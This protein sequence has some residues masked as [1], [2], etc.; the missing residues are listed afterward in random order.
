MM[1]KFMMSI[2][3]LVTVLALVGCGEETTTEST[4]GTDVSSSDAGSEVAETSESTEASQSEDNFPQ[5]DITFFVPYGAGGGYDTLARTAAPILEDNLPNDV[6]VVVKNVSGG[7]GLIGI[8]TLFKADPDG[9]SIGNMSG[10]AFIPELVG[11]G[12][13]KLREFSWLGLMS[14]DKYVVAASTESGIKSLEDLRNKDVV[15]QG[16]TGSTTIDGVS[17]IILP[18][19]LDYTC[20]GIAHNGSKEAVL[21][22]LRGDVDIVVY[23]FNVLE[24][25]ILEGELN[26]VMVATEERIKSLPDVPTLAEL[27]YPEVGKFLTLPRPIAAPPGVP[28]DRM[29]ILREAWEAVLEDPNYV[30]LVENKNKA[31]IDKATAEGVQEM[32][33]GQFEMVE[34]YEDVINAEWE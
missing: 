3:V 14:V 30:D 19:V 8:N 13:Y 29:Q 24:D 33:D 34:P 23:P 7:G 22:A 15:L 2:L 26:G 17:S 10:G 11:K 18:D 20:K 9:Y 16:T 27:G 21:A 31:L 1:Q 5:E 4:E 25:L 6:S 32:W 28:Q 12:E